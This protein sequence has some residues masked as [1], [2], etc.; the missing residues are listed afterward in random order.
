MKREELDRYVLRA[1]DS[2][3][4]S[5]MMEAR[6]LVVQCGTILEQ[7]EAEL[8]SVLPN[9]DA[10]GDSVVD[11]VAA[12][13]AHVADLNASLTESREL[14]AEMAAK[15]EACETRTLDVARRHDARTSRLESEKA[16]LEADLAT[17]KARRVG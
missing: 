3:L 17:E 11:V 15:L 9:P 1:P 4:K 13:V 16:R 2:P 14:A 5:G 12:V 8:R 6:R 7:V 10:P